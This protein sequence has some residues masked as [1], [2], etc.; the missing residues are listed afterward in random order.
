MQIFPTIYDHKTHL[1]L[2]PW[3]QML[4]NLRSRLRQLPP[5]RLL[6]LRHLTQ[7]SSATWSSNRHNMAFR[8][9]PSLRSV[10]LRKIKHGLSR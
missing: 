10:L 4:N 1:A 9:S 6:V 2:Y 5:F 8:S 3:C 7:K